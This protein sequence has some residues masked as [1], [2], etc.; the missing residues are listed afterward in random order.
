MMKKSVKINAL[1]NACKQLLAVI[2]PMITITYVTRTLQEVN[3]GKLKFARSISE[4]FVLLAGLGLTN[5]A[6]REGSL[7]KN[8]KKDFK[9]F[10]DQIFSINL[11]SMAVSYVV[12]FIF[13]FSSHIDKSV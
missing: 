8:K 10:V 11:I 4:Y 3:Y 1:L 2:Y 9:K 7:I 12:L 13:L 6:I 5:Y